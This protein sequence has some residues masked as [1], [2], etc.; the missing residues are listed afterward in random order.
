MELVGVGVGTVL[1]LTLGQDKGWMQRLERGKGWARDGTV[2]WALRLREEAS[3]HGRPG[4][5]QGP[6]LCQQP[7]PP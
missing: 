4:S 5:P 2:P 3:G 7:G 6:S 1:V